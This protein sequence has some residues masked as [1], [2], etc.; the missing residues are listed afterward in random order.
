MPFE[1][2]EPSVD[3]T[4][5]SKVVMLVALATNVP[6][7]A[8]EN[9]DPL[10]NYTVSITDTSLFFIGELEKE[11]LQAGAEAGASFEGSTVGEKVLSRIINVA[12]SAFGNTPLA[13]V[14]QLRDQTST[15]LA[16]DGSNTAGTG[17]LGLS[18]FVRSA[19]TMT[20]YNAGTANT[21]LAHRIWTSVTVNGEDDFQSDVVDKTNFTITKDIPNYTGNVYDRVMV[22]LTAP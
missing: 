3:N 19:K 5:A 6:T 11:T 14:D 9:T 12:W 22:T 10:I 17:V 15:V 18:N 1:G 20:G 4:S 13:Q 2:I 7:P 16:A 8:A 21:F